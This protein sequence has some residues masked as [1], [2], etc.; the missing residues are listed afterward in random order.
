MK[1]ELVAKDHRDCALNN[2]PAVYRVIGTPG[3]K[4]YIGRRLEEMDTDAYHQV[5]DA[6]GPGEDAYWVPDGL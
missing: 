5:K 3:G 2:C 4:V 6:I 1:I